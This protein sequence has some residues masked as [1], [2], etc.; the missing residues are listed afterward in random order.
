MEETDFYVTVFLYQEEVTK[1]ILFP[2]LS[3]HIHRTGNKSDSKWWERA[4]PVLS[5]HLQ[6]KT[7][8]EGDYGFFSFYTF[9]VLGAF[10]NEKVHFYNQTNQINMTRVI[11]S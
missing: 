8:E 4:L 5:D 11:S 1:T 2:A 10:C 6:R 9:V 3:G 7:S